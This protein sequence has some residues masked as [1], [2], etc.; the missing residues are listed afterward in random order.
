M[1]LKNKLLKQ[2][3]KYITIQKKKKKVHESIK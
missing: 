2:F 1:K 3:K